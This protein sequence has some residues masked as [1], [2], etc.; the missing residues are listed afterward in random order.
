MAHFRL[1]TPRKKTTFFS[2]SSLRMKISSCFSFSSSSCSSFLFPF[3]S[4]FFYSS[5]L[6]PPPVY[7]LL[8][9]PP[10]HSCHLL[11]L[12]LLFS[13]ILFASFSLPPTLFDPLASPFSSSNL[14][15]SPCYSMLFLPSLVTPFPWHILL[16]FCLP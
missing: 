4:S 10:S 6:S 13:F 5:H 7:Q 2:I 3:S 14:F 9:S 1:L 8:F 15:L 16:L 12:F 11:L